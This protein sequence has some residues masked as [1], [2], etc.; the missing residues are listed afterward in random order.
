MKGK[1]Q[2]YFLVFYSIAMDDFPFFDG[3][4]REMW[5]ILFIFLL[6]K[7][8]V[9]NIGFD[10]KIIF[11]FLLL[12][13]IA[14]IQSLL[15][16]AI[17]PAIIYKPLMILITPYVFYRIIKVDYFKYLFNIIYYLT[18][19]SVFLYI[20]Q[21][22]LPFI[23]SFFKDLVVQLF[24]YSWDVWPR[25][26]IIHTISN[27]RVEEFGLYRY[28]GIFHEPGATAIYLVLM[29]I[30]NT[31]F[32]GKPF[33]RKNIFLMLAT[34][35]TFSTT[36]YVMLFIYVGY[37]I[38]KG[39][40]NKL[41]KYSIL[42][43]FVVLS[44]NIYFG[45]SF[46]QEKIEQRTEEEIAVIENRNDWGRGRLFSIYKATEV[47]KTAPI[48]GRNFISAT[49]I[50]ESS[51]GY[52]I[53]GIFA[54]LGILIGVFYVYYFYI[55]LKKIIQYYETCN[56]DFSIVV[57]IIIHIGLLT[58]VFSYH[59]AFMM[60]IIVGLIGLPKRYSVNYTKNE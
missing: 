31:F 25:S 12:F 56:V 3:L 13:T 47:I 1:F 21:S 17:S 6:L 22:S 42:T 15:Y 41:I 55:G 33:N 20:L 43:G 23:D 51:F 4:I 14:T 10:R 54:K 46:L 16:Q 58:Q 35:V 38:Y 50:D 11:G 27:Y 18:I 9:Q 49:K 24:P 59:I 26:L 36:A 30:L 29:I 2:N 44:L 57:F 60:P 28:Y 5:F 45:A 34:L 39:S 48:F 19:F 37:W 52:G 7:I 40:M 32:T 53:P 8:I